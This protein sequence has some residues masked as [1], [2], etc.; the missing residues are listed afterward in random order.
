MVNDQ[1]RRLV[2]I[3]HAALSFLQIAGLKELEMFVENHLIIKGGLATLRAAAAGLVVGLAATHATAADLDQPAQSYSTPYD[4]SGVYIGGVVGY[5]WGKD[6]TVESGSW[7]G[8]PVNAEYGYTLDGASGGIKAGVNFQSGSF[9]YGAEADIE[10]ANI[11]GGFVDRIQNAGIGNDRYDWQGSVRARMGYAMD[12][13]LVYGTGGVS[14]AHIENTY[15]QVLIPPVT[16]EP[17][18][19][20]RAGW[21]IGAGVDYAVTDKIIL[22]A[23]YRYT[24]YNAFSNVSTVAFPGVT[25]EQDPSSHAVRLTLSYKF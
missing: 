24:D 13:V 17:F 9:V 2:F 22:G 1:T 25:G 5:N 14:F 3:N 7:L 6:S 23:E 10:M 15:S 16:S 12:R 20:V 11:R 21:N 4:W 8:F 19:K 18:D